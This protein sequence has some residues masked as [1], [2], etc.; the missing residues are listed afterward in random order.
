MAA[1]IALA[2][3]SNAPARAADDLDTLR[4]E[5]AQLKAALA[6]SERELASA[7]GV[8]AVPVAAPE[9]QDVAK[10]EPE[11]T[12]LG[13][14]VVRSR[15]AIDLTHDIP[16][17]VS[18]VS[19]KELSRE[20]AQDLS[21]FA[22]R[23]ANISFNQNNTRGA[24]LSIRGVGKRSFTET[25]DPS[26][27]VILDDV[28]FGL[29]QLGNFDFYDVDTVEVARGPQGTLGGKG[30]SS[31]V[32]TVNTKHPSFTPSADFSLTFGQRQTVIAQ[33][34][35]GGPIV[36]GLLAWRGAV[37]AN[38]SG[39]Y[40]E[41]AYDPDNFAL[42]NKNRLS[43]RVQFLLTPTPDLSV[44]FS[45]DLE[46]KAAQ[47][48]N[49]LTFYHDAPE[50]FANGSLTDPS[51]V[52]ARAKL[53]GFTNGSG[54]QVGP[55]AWF[56][57]RNGYTYENGYVGGELRESVNFNENQGQT[58]SN[59][60][61][62]TRVDWHSGGLDLA[63]ITAWRA[64][65]FRAENDEGTPFDISK[66][67]GG[68][69]RYRQFS[70]EFRVNATPSPKFDYQAGT[71]FLKTWDEIAS[72]AGWGSDAGAWFATDAQYNTLDRNAGSNRG[73]G[74][75]LLRESLADTFRQGTTLVRTR[76]DAVF[77]QGN[78][79]VTDAFTLTGGL[80]VTREDRDTNDVVFLSGGGVG[81]ALNP[82]AVRGVALGGF[83]TAANGTLTGANSDAQ[84]RLADTGANRYYG[85]PAG[86]A[87][88]DAYR[89]LTVAQ[90][91]QVAAAKA[92][93]S[94]QIGQ[95]ISG[96]DSQYNDRLLTSVL[97]PHYKFSPELTA[98][99]SWQHGEKSGSAINV[100]GTPTVVRPETTNAFELGLKSISRDKN[101]TL[102]AN[103][104][105]TNIRDY[106]QTV[107]VI[108][109]FTTDRNIANGQANPLAYVAA[110]GNVN[111]VQAKGLEFDGVYQGIPHTALRLSGAYN[112]ARYKDY[113]NAPKP[114]ELAYL[115]EN[116]IDMSGQRLAGAAK[117]TFNAGAEYT[118]PVFG[119]KLFHTSFN[120]AF[121]SRFNNTDTLSSYGWV[122]GY[123]LTDASIGISTKGGFDLNLVIKN[124]FD[125]RAHEPGW[126]SYAPDP[127]PRWIGLVFSG[128]L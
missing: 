65:S 68:G 94:G 85:V 58:V 14:V 100:N 115:P 101:L 55:R 44:L 91:A 22:K 120:T 107:S 60:G 49:G 64:T 83:A 121:T 54:V 8:V 112:D 89:A 17:S 25:Q 3:I 20:L 106:Q 109:Q 26:V 111:R 118:H 47:L 23:G 74:L 102:N 90:L 88:G 124:A 119:D 114:D 79:H 78:W 27:G 11:S 123:S 59:K 48:Q 6:K 45:A 2:L 13:E 51:G 28:S 86:A 4:A 50:R 105:L 29:T 95:L 39:G 41:N 52:S 93:R 80:R 35:L 127:Y 67:G 84:L 75:A 92:L 82:V 69:V 99:T 33:A 125:K 71:Y 9:P 108:D 7:R 117:W 62:S 73:A 10:A 66:L 30:A 34:A 18:V 72:K 96:V 57:G 15:K 43:G 63:S 19:G 12:E 77:G 24:S 56:Q 36:D 16:Q 104:F 1:L 113:K 40:Y 61:A 31:G 21:A 126:V 116:F 76:S 70:Q 42:Y 5:V 122:G 110:Q 46:P 81:A 37:V 38:R 98:Y 97:S 103:L 128:K 87:P 32:V 53:L